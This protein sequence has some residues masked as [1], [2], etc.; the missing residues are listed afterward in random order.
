MIKLLVDLN[1]EEKGVVTKRDCAI[2]DIFPIVIYAEH[3]GGKDDDVVFDTLIIEVLFNDTGDAIVRVDPTDRPVVGELAAR[4]GQSRDFFRPGDIR[5]MTEITAA[6]LRQ[7]SPLSLF[8]FASSEP[9]GPYLGRTGRAGL[10]NFKQPFRLRR[11]DAPV[12]VAAGKATAGLRAN[13]AGTTRI[14]PVGL[15]FRGFEA[16]PILSTPSVLKIRPH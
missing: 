1:L 15:A 3:G 16:V 6:S 10:S 4:Y 11:G 7:A 8:G 14:L 13:S 2:G 12:S 5:G 9:A